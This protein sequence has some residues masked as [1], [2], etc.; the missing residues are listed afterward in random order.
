MFP[1][2]E[3]A[4][5]KA[6]DDDDDGKDTVGDDGTVASKDVAAGFIRMG[7]LP[8]I[9]FI[10]EVEKIAGANEPLLSVVIALACHSP[11]AANAVVKCP[12]LMDSIIQQFFLMD[13]D[14]DSEVGPL[15]PAHTKAIQLLKVLLQASRMN[16]IR[17]AESGALQVAQCELY[18]QGY[19]M[20]LHRLH[21]RPG[22]ESFEGVRSTIIESLRLWRVCI[23][24]RMG[25][26][27]FS[28]IYPA[29]CFWL[30]PLSAEE[31]A[32]DNKEDALYLAQE[33]YML[34]ESL[35]QTLPRLHFQEA[36]MS[37]N[38]MEESICLNWTWQV[39]IPLVGTAIRWL[40]TDRISAVTEQLVS[41]AYGDEQLLTREDGSRTKLVGMLASLFHFLATVSEK[42]LGNDDKEG[43]ITDSPTPWL[44]T[45]IPQLGLLLASNQILNYRSWDSEA[46]QFGSE[47]STLF[48]S[49]CAIRRR[50]DY[51]MSLAATSC[52]HGLVR[53]LNI[54]DRVI[55][56]SK[57]E[58][59]LQTNV[60]D[61]SEDQQI[62]FHGL[63]ASG[64]VEL[65]GLLA[66]VGKE[67]MMN[68]HILQSCEENGRGGPAPGLGL[69]WGSVG[70]GAWS[71]EVLVAQASARLVAEL[72]EVLPPSSGSISQAFDHEMRRENSLT[73]DLMWRISCGF[74]IAAISDP[75]NGDL[76]EKSY[77]K[78][79]LHPNVLEC[80]FQNMEFILK[81]RDIAKVSSSWMKNLDL[82]SKLDPK[83]VQ[84]LLLKN[85]RETWTSPKLPKS[86][87]RKDDGNPKLSK[88]QKSGRAPSRLA[89]VCEEEGSDS[90]YV[91]NSLMREWA[92]QRLP[93]PTHWLL[94]PMA[95]NISQ[96]LDGSEGDVLAGGKVSV[97]VQE[98]LEMEQ[99][100]KAG[101]LWLLS[102]EALNQT[103]EN[104]EST[105]IA[106]VPLIRKLH[107]LSTV[108]VLGGDV[109]LHED[110]QEMVGTLQ[111]FYGHQLDSWQTN[112]H[113]KSDEW[114]S[115]MGSMPLDFDHIDGTYSTFA[116]TLSEQFG[117]SSYGDLVFAR[118]VAIYLRQGVPDSV[119]L[120]IWRGLAD[121]HVLKLLPPLIQC[122]GLQWGY[123]YPFERNNQMVEV[124]VS[125]W[126]SGAYDAAI[127]Q[128]SMSFALA[129]HHIFGY[130][131]VQGNI[132][133]EKLAV[134]KVIRTLV[135]SSTRKS[136]QQSMLK[137]LLEYQPPSPTKEISELSSE[138]LDKRV[139][140]LSTACK[141]DLS[142][143]AQV[144][145]LRRMTTTA[146]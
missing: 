114:R 140:L 66:L 39:A 24:Y 59:A 9:R 73:S 145:R 36:G 102:L 92:R 116:E 31:I 19:P 95:T 42:I 123:L 96:I 75:K 142:L 40:S 47:K 25:I 144:E 81:G 52:L 137:Q 122:C 125:A 127:A 16:C 33:S 46:A 56:S 41:A 82:S 7:I 49:L 26:S 8:R 117:A 130:I 61:S 15:R 88:Q 128:H 146:R 103:R 58:S 84:K 71:K 104:G 97:V 3:R 83:L 74:G 10:L 98:K 62:L 22:E 38:E 34:L 86:S 115:D 65:R 90:C 6:D 54:L 143:V 37:D 136:Q 13:D 85:F 76:V 100:V 124:Y 135:R 12:R 99:V 53:L 43:S 110:V 121:A 101:I 11:A 78:F 87:K 48:A 69:G 72:L 21:P 32:S 106:T 55:G 94:S 68:G 105:F 14:L 35:A 112:K 118:Q 18:K 141:G 63:V 70:G 126:T 129:L 44:P 27:L 51:E 134:D 131:F 119:R 113:T 1:F 64:A 67:V 108:F 77:S 2:S 138:E 107:A 132:V 5:S 4:S 133:K 89:T 45:F 23:H 29:L 79:L 60:G 80:L 93:L 109:F 50:G 17:F 20:Q 30:A 28:D 120:A 57:P 139:R 111:E 91:T